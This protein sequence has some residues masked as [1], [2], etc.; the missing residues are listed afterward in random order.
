MPNLLHIADVL[1]K[2][3]ALIETY[4]GEKTAAVK[5]ERDAR[6]KGLTERYAA[7]TGDELPSDVAEKLAA[8]DD[9]VF[10]TVQAMVEKTAGTVESLGRSGE[11]RDLDAAPV[12]RVERAKAAYERFGSFITNS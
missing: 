3:A 12:T 11:T 2:A 9:S 10:K 5:V 8:G 1:E 6:V 7:A 4:E